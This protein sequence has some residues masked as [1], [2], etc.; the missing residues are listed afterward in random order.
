[1]EN[2]PNEEKLI[3]E[4]LKSFIEKLRKTSKIKIITYLYIYEL[5]KKEHIQIHVL[6]NIELDK[7]LFKLKD[8][9][10]KIIGID[11]EQ[12]LNFQK[13]D[14]N[15]LEIYSDYILKLLNKSFLNKEI[16]ER[17]ILLKKLGVNSRLFGGSKEFKEFLKEISGS[18]IEIPITFEK[19]EDAQS[20]DHIVNLLSQN[21]PEVTRDQI[22]EEITIE[23]KNYT[24]AFDLIK[25]QN[26]EDFL[27]KGR[28]KI[29]KGY[30]KFYNF[31]K[32]I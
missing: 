26:L 21:Y 2:Y 3:K 12:V 24:D 4:H 18:I 6:S 14:E 1:M 17:Q 16:S 9:W 23:L 30:L 22:E 25:Y 31:I 15:I 28:S 19:P 20:L 32:E 8:F 29:S 11:N 5:H 7:Q 13:V 27:K 10:K